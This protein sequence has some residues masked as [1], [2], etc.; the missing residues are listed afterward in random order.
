MTAPVALY[1][2]FDATGA[3]LYVGVSLNAVQRLR[4]HRL[5]PW[6]EDIANVTVEYY[7]DRDAALNAERQAIVDEGPL[8][9]RAHNPL[10]ARRQKPENGAL[11]SFRLK[12][13]LRL[14]LEAKAKTQRRTVSNLVR[15][16]LA[17][18]L[19]DRAP[20]HSFQKG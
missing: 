3:L 9:N 20:P 5:S 8:H 7:A 10:V 16:V 18:W 17:D 1:R 6:T 4:Q 15:I 14:R 13:E 12:P 11:L 2:H 19:A